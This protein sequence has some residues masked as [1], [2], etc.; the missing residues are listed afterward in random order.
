MNQPDVECASS[1]NVVNYLVPDGSRDEI[2]KHISNSKILENASL[3]S[4][5]Q[6]ETLIQKVCKK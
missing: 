5:I 6:T 4:D 1:E 3:K 2:V